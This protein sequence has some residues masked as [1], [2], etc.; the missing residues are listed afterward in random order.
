MIIT[1]GSEGYQ[2]SEPI[3]EMFDRIAL[4]REAHKEL[5]DYAKSLGIIPFS[6]PFSIR[7]L[8]FLENLD[9]PCIKVAASDVNYLDMHKELPKTNKPV[10]LSLGKCTLSEADKVISILLDG[11]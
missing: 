6:T 4:P 7:G 11:G 2:K 10:M 8:R 3:G 1:W 5:F 9:V